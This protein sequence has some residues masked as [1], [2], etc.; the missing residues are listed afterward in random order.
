MLV[1]MGEL[2]GKGHMLCLLFLSH[3]PDVLLTHCRHE[4]KITEVGT[5]R[6]AQSGVRESIDGI[7]LI[8]ISRTGIPTVNTG[9]GSRLNHAV[10]HHG[11][12]VGM[13]VSSCSDERIHK[14]RIVCFFHLTGGAGCQCGKGC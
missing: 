2:G 14:C 1:V 10:R 3:V 5:P 11:T 13:T 6:A 12:G 8:I 9:V 4:Q 7:I